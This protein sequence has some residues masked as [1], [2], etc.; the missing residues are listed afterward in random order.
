MKTPNNHLPIYT[1]A[2][3]IWPV[4]TCIDHL[5]ERHRFRKYLL[6][7]DLGVTD[8]KMLTNILPSNPLYKKID[9][10]VYFEAI[11]VG[12]TKNNQHVWLSFDFNGNPLFSDY[13][14]DNL[15]DLRKKLKER[16]ESWKQSK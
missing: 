10:D 3:Y 11:I 8:E 13:Q 4:Y 7:G 2:E 1:F 6:A 12:S 15:E 16:K 5:G 14:F 9:I